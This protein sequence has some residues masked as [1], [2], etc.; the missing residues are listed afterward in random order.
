[1]RRSKRD[2]W[3]DTVGVV[4]AILWLIGSTGLVLGGAVVGICKLVKWLM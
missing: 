2:D 1:M 3:I 4:I